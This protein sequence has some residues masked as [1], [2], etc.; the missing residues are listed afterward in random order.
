MSTDDVMSN[1]SNI[2]SERSLGSRRSAIAAAQ[3]DTA[4]NESVWNL[5]FD[6]RNNTG[7]QAV[8]HEAKELHPVAQ[9][10]HPP[11]AD[12]D[13]MG[14]VSIQAFERYLGR[15]TGSTH[16]T[17]HPDITSQE[18]NLSND[19]VNNDGYQTTGSVSVEAFELQAVAQVHQLPDTDNSDDDAAG[20]GNDQ[21]NNTGYQTTGSVSN[22]AFELQVMAEVH[23]PPN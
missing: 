23:Q 16:G 6:Q 8:S 7:D 18:G 10:Q 11:K 3:S 19:E 13:T 2:G 9:V 5:Q 21:V 1:V 12:D 22:E 17:I 20:R 4:S 15:D 14:N